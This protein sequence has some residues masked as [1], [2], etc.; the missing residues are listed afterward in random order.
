MLRADPTEPR[1]RRHRGLGT[2]RY[3]TTVTLDGDVLASPGAE[4]TGRGGIR[5]TVQRVS[6]RQSDDL[7][8]YL[9]S[10]FNVPNVFAS[11]GHALAH[12][13]ERFQ[14]ADC[15]DVITGAARRAGARIDY[16]SVA[17]LGRYARPVTDRL[18]LDATGLTRDEG[19]EAGEP[20]TLRFGS[21]VRRGDL[22]LIDYVGF[23]GSPRAWDHVAVVAADAGRPGVFDPADRV[24]HMGYLYGLTDVP[25]GAEGPAVVQFLRFRP[26]WQRA[27]RRHQARLAARE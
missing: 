8:G 22:M 21:D 9:T 20:L 23:E 27:F 16:A 26:R 2:M 5:E 1:L 11:A 7:A 6:F 14:G 10:Y 13:T 25:A 18:V 4:A 3:K 17:G 12:Q 19:E 24:L 15:A